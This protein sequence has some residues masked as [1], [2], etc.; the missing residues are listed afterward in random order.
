ML[1]LFVL[2]VTGIAII[3]SGLMAGFFWAWDVAVMQGLTKVE[4]QVAIAAMQAINANIR[5][6]P[7]GLGFFGTEVALVVAALLAFVSR[8]ALWPTWS[9]V[10]AA[11]VYFL[12]VVLVTLARN[13][14]LNELLSN[15]R[16]GIGD[17]GAIWADYAVP[18][19]GWNR[20]RILAAVVVLALAASS[21]MTSAIEL[22]TT[23]RRRR[24]RPY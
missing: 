2:L 3:L 19:L 14:P 24:S 20:L 18:W 6:L 22:A 16:A 15:A 13:A 12:G 8:T 10:G 7:F 17:P 9:L 4:P 21:L 1:R 23:R 11:L 5:N